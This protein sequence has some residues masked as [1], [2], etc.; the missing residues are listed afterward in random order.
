MPT[1]TETDLQHHH[2]LLTKIDGKTVQETPH[3]K[4][5]SIEIGEKMSANGF[6]G[7]NGY[8]GQAELQDGKLRVKDM[9]MTRKMCAP[10]KMKTEQI[11]GSV[12]GQWSDIT[13]TKEGMILKGQQHTLEFTLRD[14]VY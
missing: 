5:A 10:D 2:W 14:W 6:A 4:V 7:C 3:H 9:G 8:F 12:L 1:V 13:L 11:M